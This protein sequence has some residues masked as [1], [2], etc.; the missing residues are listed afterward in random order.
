VRLEVADFGAKK[1]GWGCDRKEIF[2]PP[3]NLD[4]ADA[5]L[6]PL[7]RRAAEKDAC[8]MHA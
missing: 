2:G 5:G 7:V 6:N 8:T 4:N 1:D 3:M